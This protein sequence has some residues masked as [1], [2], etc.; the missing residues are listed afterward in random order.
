MCPT[1]PVKSNSYML[2][3]HSEPPVG[4]ENYH[5]LKSDGFMYGQFG[6]KK[7]ET[8]DTEVPGARDK[9]TKYITMYK[10]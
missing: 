7:K 2:E 3:T 8:P 9:T 10:A 1:L 6:L 4:G 5:V